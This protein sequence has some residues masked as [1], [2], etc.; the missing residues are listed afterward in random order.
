[1]RP[2]TALL[3]GWTVLG[4]IAGSFL[5]AFIHRW[6]RGIS[7]VRRTRS[8][9]PSCEATIAWYDNIPVLSYLVLRGKCR[10]CGGAIP[11]RYLVVEL[12]A[13]GLFAAAF[14]RGILAD[15]A[16]GWSFCLVAS[17][18]SGVLIAVSFIDI[19]TYTVPVVA[20]L[21]VVPVGLLSSA[22][23]P[24][25]QPLPTAWTG[26][27]GGDARLDALFNS[28]QGIIMGG[29]LVWATGA[30]AELLIRKEAMGGGDVK[31]LAGVG[32]VLGWKAACV[33]F[34]LAVFVGAAVGVAGIAL[35]KLARALRA[36]RR[37]GRKKGKGERDRER[38]E[39][40]GITYRYGSR[41]AAPPSDAEVVRSPRLL[42]LGL[43]IAVEQAASLYLLPGA[44]GS[45]GAQAPL[46]FGATLGFFMVFYDVLRRRLVGEGRWIRR[47]IERGEDG[48]VEEHLAGHY[49]PFGPFL[50]VASV[51]VLFFGEE[52]VAWTAARFFGA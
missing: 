2:E 43:A 45:W 42:V 36:R 6:P 7:L 28:V 30:A 23:F 15:D 11:V 32:A 24:H 10:R 27:E 12:L 17:F 18:V 21:V 14:Y 40:R 5:N 33:S 34:V 39:R 22:V 4:A 20:T 41:E 25:L 9:C 51:V 47:E 29:G 49:L 1:M 31:I 50:A 44:R 26:A 13:T 48:S 38:K 52:I 3:V 37:E 19:E 46:Y 16:P 35:Q 8:F